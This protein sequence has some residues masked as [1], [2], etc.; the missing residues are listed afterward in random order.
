MLQFFSFLLMWLG[1][2]NWFFISA[3]QYDFVAGLFGTQSSIFSR[4]I[5][6]FIGLAGFAVALNLLKNKGKFN[7]FDGFKKRQKQQ[8]VVTPVQVVAD[9]QEVAADEP[10][11]PYVPTPQN[12]FQP[13]ISTPKSGFK[14]F[15]PSQYDD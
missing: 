6:F 13:I 3:F 8:K 14:D 7:L 10:E 1:S 2:F 11:M 5:Y 12:T 4:F 9:E 15:D